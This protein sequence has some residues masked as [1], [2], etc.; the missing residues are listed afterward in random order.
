MGYD[1]RI[2]REFYRLLD[3]I[4]ELVKVVKVLYLINIGEIVKYKNKDFDEI[5]F[6]NVG[7]NFMCL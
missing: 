2:Y 6:D 3:F 1:I 4:F 5:E 7:N